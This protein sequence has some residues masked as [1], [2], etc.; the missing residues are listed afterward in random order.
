MQLL[1]SQNDMATIRLFDA[2]GGI[3]LQITNL[4]KSF[5]QKTVLDNITQTIYDG[6]KIG[7]IGSNGQ[8]KSTL[9]NIINNKMEADSGS[10]SSSDIIGYLEQ[11][12]TIKA[13]Q[14]LTQFDSSTSSDLIQYLKRFKIDEAIQFTQ[15][16]ISS[17]SCGE[18][19]KIA[20]ALLLAQSPTMLILDEP[21]N[22]LD[23]EGKKLLID[24]IQ[25]TEKTCLVVSHDIDFLNKTVN[26]IWEIEAGKITEYYCNYHDYREA[27]KL[28]KLS[29]QNAYEKQQKRV[30]EI[31]HDIAVYKQASQ[32]SGKKKRRGQG[33]RWSNLRQDVAEKKLSKF[34]S[35]KIAQLEHEL[36]KDIA[37]P[38][39][40]HII[41]YY[42]NADE[43]KTTNVIYAE[44]FGKKYEDRILYQHGHFII[45]S[46]D[47]V[48]I[49][50]NNGC[51]KST[52]IKILLGQT[53]Y[54]GKLFI[55]PSAKIATLYQDVY[56]LD[57][58]TTIND[59]SNTLD[60]NY[61]TKFIQN[62]V[63]MNIDKTRFDT[64]IK[65]LSSGE[66]MRIKLTNIIL[67]DTNLIILDEPTNHLDIENK[68]YLQK[69]L[70]GFAGTILI[71][72]HDV[73]FLRSITTKT[74]IIHDKKI[75]L[76]DN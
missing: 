48:G 59:L 31:E 49:M 62:L 75:E 17:I 39:K 64:K 74:L 52:F 22:H 32:E 3:M 51:G 14:L 1:G 36:N 69:V 41:K 65:Y 43:I 33:G 34:A 72:S 76:L 19:T 71:V 29:I 7:L 68:E 18:K 56:D 57:E 45:K 38:E 61:K 6:E 58:E 27:K 47:K 15:E 30:K 44:D 16:S 66:K 9:L 5:G 35:A 46:G 73:D 55:T 8:G 60:K 37:S 24:Y 70:Q 23:I 28:E 20:L 42:L 53:D 40:E 2:L 25:N 50:G 21:T 26:K 67:S 11:G 63:V 13:E 12:S 10:I 54:T 4:S